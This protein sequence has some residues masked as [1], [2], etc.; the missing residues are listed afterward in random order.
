[1]DEGTWITLQSFE[2]SRTVLRAQAKC[3]SASTKLRC[4][5]FAVET[6]YMLIKTGGGGEEAIQNI[7]ERNEITQS[8]SKPYE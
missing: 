3:V 4:V 1:M 2:V 6:T 7:P 8:S 5:D